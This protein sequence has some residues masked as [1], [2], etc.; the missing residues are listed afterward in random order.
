AQVHGWVNRWLVI[1]LFKERK[2]SP[3]EA[4]EILSTDLDGFFKMLDEQGILYE[5]FRQNHGDLPRVSPTLS[6]L[7]Q[8]KSIQAMLEEQLAEARYQL[9]K[10]QQELKE[11]D[12]VRSEF[13]ATVS[14]EL[15][16]PLNSIIGFAKL[17]LNQSIGPLNEVQH[18]DISLIYNSA[19][20][21]QDLV[22]DILDLSKIDA[23]KIRLDMEWLAIE[24]IIAGVIPTT[25]ILIEDKPIDLREEIEPKLPK[26]FVDRGRVRQIVLNL[27]SNAAKFTDAGAISLRIYR[28]SKDGEPFICF[29]VKDTGIGIADNDADKVF[30]AFRQIDSSVGR[31]AEGTGLG[32]PISRRLAHLHG[33]DLWFES[34]AGQGSTFYL[35]VPVNPP[36]VVRANISRG[37]E[38]SS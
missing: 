8:T 9:Y 10:V 35:S 30:E 4:A 38:F 18:T 32:M 33:G 19:L 23:G 11:A 37:K 13:I 22:N 21:L 2:I 3:V 27:L 26:I 25:M 14:H 24:E 5:N 34:K 31:R 36:D 12:K 7:A 6:D 17:L 29:A 28:M 1:S 20:H 16:T 15:R